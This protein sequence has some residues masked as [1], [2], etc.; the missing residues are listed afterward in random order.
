[1]VFLARAE[2]KV[3]LVARAEV[4]VRLVARAKVKVRVG[5][6]TDSLGGKS[7]GEGQR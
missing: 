6:V 7:R 3:R 1:M 4:K 2:V 5:G